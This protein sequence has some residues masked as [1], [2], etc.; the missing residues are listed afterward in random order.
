MSKNCDTSI[1]L[2][3]GNCLFGAVTLNMNADIDKFKYSAYGTGFDEKG[4]FS[5]RSG[6]TSRNV[7][8]F[9]VIMSSS[10]KID[11]KKKKLILGPAQRLEH[12]LAA[13]K[14]YSINFT[15]NN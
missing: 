15:E 1:Y 3:L 6:G 5:Y 13:E 10:A 11:N 14:M 4:F 2:T 7:I 12:T 9:G 8:I